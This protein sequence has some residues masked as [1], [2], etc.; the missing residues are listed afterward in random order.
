MSGATLAQRLWRG[1]RP[2]LAAAFVALTA[3]GVCGDI[4]ALAAGGVIGFVI[5]RRTRR[6]PT[7]VRQLGILV[8]AGLGLG[9]LVVVGQ[10][11]LG[12]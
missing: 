11:W 5:E 1:V 7:A 9:A 2:L 3:F 10:R 4:R 12:H 6:A 8:A